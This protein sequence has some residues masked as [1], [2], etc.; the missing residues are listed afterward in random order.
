MCGALKHLLLLFF[1]IDHD[2]IPIKVSDRLDHTPLKQLINE[3][4]KTIA[5]LSLLPEET[6][7]VFDY[8][9]ISIVDNITSTIKN[10][11]SYVLIKVFLGAVG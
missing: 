2:A 7:E 3:N 11:P 5:E 6:K 1:R 9:L 4:K 10:S 8:L